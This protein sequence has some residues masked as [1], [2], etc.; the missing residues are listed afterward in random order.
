MCLASYNKQGPTE[1]GPASADVQN[2]DPHL[3]NRG[4]LQR[5]HRG[6]VFGCQQMQLALDLTKGMNWERFSNML[7]M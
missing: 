3:S 5:V 7:S 4:N 6:D 1:D 2:T